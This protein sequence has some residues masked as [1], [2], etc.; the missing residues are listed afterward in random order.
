[1]G[2][3]AQKGFQCQRQEQLALANAWPEAGDG[4]V[5]CVSCFSGSLSLKPEPAWTLCT[6]YTSP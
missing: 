3:K 4:M 1:M 5:N 6:I 2:A